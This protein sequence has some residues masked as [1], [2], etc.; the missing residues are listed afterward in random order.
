MKQRRLGGNGPKVSSLG[1]GAMGINL[2]YG[3][4]DTQQGIATIR[5]AYEAGITLFDTAELYG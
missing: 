4:S 1:Y 2:A 3:A 5:Q